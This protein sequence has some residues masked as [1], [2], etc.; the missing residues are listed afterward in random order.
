MTKS[1]LRWLTLAAV[2]AVLAGCATT[3]PPRKPGQ[4]NEAAWQARKAAL[5]KLSRWTMDARAGSGGLFGWSGSLHWVQAGRH[6]DIRVAGPLGIGAVRIDGVPG[7][8]RV[9]TAQGTY[10]TSHPERLL[11]Q[12]LNITLPVSG[13]R[14][15]ALGLPKPG[16]PA[17]VR[18]DSRGLLRHMRQDG[19]TL[20]YSRYRKT[21][22][23]ELPQRLTATQGSTRVRIAVERWELPGGG[24]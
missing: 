17:Q 13:L 1:V 18:V 21:Q 24:R 10:R 5:G 22:G 6:F 9:H 12:Q 8:I 16:E 2:L 14:F 19:W 4:P 11:R 3:V 23:H 15:W 20:T 7:S